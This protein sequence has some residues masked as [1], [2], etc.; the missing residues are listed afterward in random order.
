MSA[1]LR[2]LV[3][4]FGT[5]HTVIFY[6]NFILTMHEGPD[7]RDQEPAVDTSYLDMA[8]RETSPTA[9][10][11]EV[12]ETAA[13]EMTFPEAEA[14]AYSTQATELV[15]SIQKEIQANPDIKEG[16]GAKLLA[17][18]LAKLDAKNTIFAYSYMDIVSDTGDR[19][20]ESIPDGL[21][22]AKKVFERISEDGENDP[23]TG[24]N[25]ANAAQETQNAFATQIRYLEGVKAAVQTTAAQLE[26]KKRLAGNSA[27]QGEPIPLNNEQK[28]EAH[29]EL[30]N[31]L[32]EG[33]VEGKWDGGK[34][35]EIRDQILSLDP[36][37]QEALAQEFFDNTIGSGTI[38]TSSKMDAVLSVYRRIPGAFHEKF[39][40]L[41]SARLQSEGFGPL[42]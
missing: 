19:I 28:S 34:G 27:E 5:I 37:A 13:E 32:M 6:L 41:E 42:Q 16:E 20:K 8:T 29:P 22:D 12:A 30:S 15:E 40:A 7:K 38:D 18:N 3:L 17:E 24:W 36:S 25:K 14:E 26:V 10:A 35:F 2:F 9:V 39:K 1:G 31:A 33:L 21:E 11:P 4:I 23:T